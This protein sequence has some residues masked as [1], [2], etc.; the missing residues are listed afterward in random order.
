MK[1]L[2]NK[3][4]GRKREKFEEKFIFFSV[5]IFIKDF[6]VFKVDR[7]FMWGWKYYLLK[8]SF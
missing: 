8:C 7:I 5:F 3:V 2:S 1:L 6:R 4:G